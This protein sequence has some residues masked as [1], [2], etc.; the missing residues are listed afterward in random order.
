MS[1]LTIALDIHNADPR[2]TDPHDV[3]DAL[4]AEEFPTFSP[5]GTF[6]VEDIDGTV[7]YAEWT[8]SGPEAETAARIRSAL[9]NLVDAVQGSSLTA[10]GHAAWS[11]ASTLLE[12]T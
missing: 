2:L 11:A 7:A 10:E 5:G 6:S 3:A 12:T 1:R 8:T 4:L 9:A